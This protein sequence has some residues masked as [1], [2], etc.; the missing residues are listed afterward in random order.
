VRITPRNSPTIGASADPV[1][2]ETRFGSGGDTTDPDE[3]MLSDEDLEQAQG[4]E[5]A[6]AD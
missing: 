1:H 4:E 6:G 3:R 5:E 2:G